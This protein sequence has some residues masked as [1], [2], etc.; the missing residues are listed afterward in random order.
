[1]D[2]RDKYKEASREFLDAIQNDNYVAAK[3]HFPNV[4]DNKLKTII[5]SLKDGYLRNLAARK[6]KE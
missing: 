3:E 2:S 6:N 5:N 4:V 1:M